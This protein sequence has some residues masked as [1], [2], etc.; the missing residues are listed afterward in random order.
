MSHTGLIRPPAPQETPLLRLELDVHGAAAVK[1][2]PT[3]VARTRSR[4]AK[5]AQCTVERHRVLDVV[6]PDQTTVGTQ[7]EGGD[8]VLDPRPVQ[9]RAIPCPDRIGI[10][11]TERRR[12]D[13]SYPCQ[14]R[15]S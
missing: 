3:E 6:A 9:H 12:A 4:L 11:G 14:L 15:Q 2:M 8:H 5:V 7:G 13:R 1:I 10:A